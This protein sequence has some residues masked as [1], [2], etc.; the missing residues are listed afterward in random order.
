M[1][2]QQHFEKSRYKKKNMGDDISVSIEKAED[3]QKNCPKNK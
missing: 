3:K 1:P 2:Y